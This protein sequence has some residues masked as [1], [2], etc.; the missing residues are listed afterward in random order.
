MLVAPSHGHI[1]QTLHLI[2]QSHVKSPLPE[3]TCDLHIKVSLTSSEA[4]IVWEMKKKIS[5]YF[6]KARPTFHAHAI[7]MADKKKKKTF[8]SLPDCL[9]GGDRSQ[10]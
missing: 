1:S 7:S 10:D 9:N 3:N 8:R 4:F 2:H 6:Q 5:L